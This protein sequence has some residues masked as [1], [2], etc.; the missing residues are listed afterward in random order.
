MKQHENKDSNL[1]DMMSRGAAWILKLCAILQNLHCAFNF[2]MSA[3]NMDSKRTLCKENMILID[4]HFENQGTIETVAIIKADILKHAFNLV[5]YYF[6]ESMILADYEYINWSESIFDICT[7]I[8]NFNEAQATC[9]SQ[10]NLF[11]SLSKRM[12]KYIIFLTNKSIKIN[13]IEIC[14]G[15]SGTKSQNVIDFLFKLKKLGFGT[16]VE[17]ANMRGPKTTLFIK[18]QIGDLMNDMDLLGHLSDL[19]IDI[20][21][22][23]DISEYRLVDETPKEIQ[24]INNHKRTYNE[25]IESPNNPRNTDFSIICI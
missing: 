2:I 23:K 3:A 9:S 14:R 21:R 12:A 15:V 10:N 8:H 18:T 11:D 16:I 7:N 4:R 24:T 25:E 1:C 20:E 19:N 22:L 13:T 17:N 5:S 6:K